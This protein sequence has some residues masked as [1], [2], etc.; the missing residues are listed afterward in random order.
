[1][2]GEDVDKPG[3]VSQ[4]Y[5]PSPRFVALA[6]A[7]SSDWRPAESRRT[8]S[9]SVAAYWSAGPSRLTGAATFAQAPA[10]RWRVAAQSVR[11]RRHARSA[12]RLRRP[13]SYL[14]YE[15]KEVL[16]APTGAARARPARRC[17]SPGP[18]STILRFSSS[19]V[20]LRLS[21]RFS[22]HLARLPD[23]LAV[24]P[25]FASTCS[26]SV[27]AAAAR[28]PAPARTRSRCHAFT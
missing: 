13:P 18:R 5:Q 2:R 20:F 10:V 22:R 25:R 14:A 19:P 9:W 3:M 12:S 23:G 26:C 27:G 6:A 4:T 21:W 7:S 16:V 11:S 17:R 24:L 28:A 15:H 8:S 1:M